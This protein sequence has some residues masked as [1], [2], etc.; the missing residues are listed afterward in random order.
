VGPRA[1]LDTKVTGKIL[2]PLPRI[3]PRS[4]ICLLHQVLLSFLENAF[5]KTQE[6]HFSSPYHHNISSVKLK[7]R[8]QI[9]RKRLKH[10]IV[11]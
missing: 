7:Q 2:S 11:Q 1:G 6:E 10:L 8:N 5:L 9:Q 4:E 3:K